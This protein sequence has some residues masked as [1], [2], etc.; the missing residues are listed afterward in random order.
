[1]AKGGAD[2]LRRRG[3][4]KE[5]KRSTERGREWSR[6]GGAAERERGAAESACAVARCV[7]AV[8]I[9]SRVLSTVDEADASDL[10]SAP[11]EE[12][13]RRRMRE[14]GRRRRRE[15]ISVSKRYQG[16][17]CKSKWGEAE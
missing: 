6:E 16:E 2:R 4:Q 12:E 5:E 15:K 7:S 11:V 13:K 10:E 3:E 9:I 17:W 14:E 1:M 8:S